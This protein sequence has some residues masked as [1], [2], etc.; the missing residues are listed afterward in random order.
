MSITVTIIAEDPN[1]KYLYGLS[2]WE[3]GTDASSITDTS[4]E[5]HEILPLSDDLDGK[6]GGELVRRSTSS[7]NREL[8][9]ALERS[10]GA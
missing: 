10:A 6:P 9:I 8:I 7:R 1:L 4:H 2:S 5:S 3:M